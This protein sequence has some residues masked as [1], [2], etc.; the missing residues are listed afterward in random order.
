MLSTCAR[1]HTR[2]NTHVRATH[3]RLG[4]NRL[5]DETV[6][7]GEAYAN[8]RKAKEGNQSQQS[9]A[10]RATFTGQQHCM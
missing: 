1:T 8:A 7:H 3:R 5:S 9:R 4:E 2:K 10:M 6:E